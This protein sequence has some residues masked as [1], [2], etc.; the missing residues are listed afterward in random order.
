M[1]HKHSLDSQ[2]NQ[3]P[4]KTVS[5][6]G[7]RGYSG[8]ELVRLLLDHPFV[9]LTKCFATNAFKVSDLTWSK[10]ASEVEGLPE[11]E[12]LNKLTDVVFLATP[13]E[14]SAKYAPEIAK[15]GRIVIDLSGAFRL[16]AAESQTWY[17]LNPFEKI[18]RDQIDYGLNPF[19]GP[20]KKN[21]QIISNP[22]CYA[23]AVS[24]ALIPLLK[25]GVIETE[26]IMIDAKSGTT[27]AGK[28]ALEHLMFSEVEGDC[29]PYRV[30]SHQHLPEIQQACSQYGNATIDPHFVTSLLPVARGIVATI[31][32]RTKSTDLGKVMEAYN[33]EFASYPLVH[34][35]ED[36]GRLAKLTQVVG[37]PF[38][39]ISYVLTGN[40]LFVFT[41][42]DNLLKGA[43]SQAIENL[44]RALDL[45]AE[46]SLNR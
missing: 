37:T 32:A 26:N 15:Q 14:I 20:F 43:A 17:G 21:T 19:C 1:M 27:G 39:N 41:A 23:S 3:A 36:V 33:K 5:V 6:V 38:T 25:H 22:G 8:T 12:L 40:K 28:K 35:G 2:L 30:G 11:S 29:L 44:N 10:K 46:L 4:K 7:A 24:L 16:S 45:P 13:A 34:H 31:C 9:D 42:I 18:S